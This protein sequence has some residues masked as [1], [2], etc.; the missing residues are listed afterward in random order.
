MIQLRSWIPIQSRLQSLSVINWSKSR[1]EIQDTS[2]W[3]DDSNLCLD[4]FQVYAIIVSKPEKGELS[5]ASVSYTAG[6]YHIPVIGISSR[7]SAFSDKVRSHTSSVHH[8][9][10]N[11]LHLLQNIHVSF[12]RT[13]PPY[14]HQ[15]DVWVE[16]LKHFQYRQLVFIHASDTDGRSLLGWSSSLVLAGQ[17]NN[18]MFPGRFQTKAQD[19]DVDDHEVKVH[20]Q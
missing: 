15:A 5:P 1:W 9:V 4:M 20:K 6:F 8:P 12:L 11:I 2:L 19:L 18:I 10:W 13:V 16:L 17:S 3:W 14:S 7:D